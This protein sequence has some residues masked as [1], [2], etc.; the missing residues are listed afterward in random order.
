M[1][2]IIIKDKNSTREA[3][4]Q[5]LYRG[6]QSAN[7]RIREISMRNLDRIKRETSRT[8]SMRQELVKAHRNNDRENIKD[9]HDYIQNKSEYQAHD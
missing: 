7:P 5:E 2:Y 6:T 1:V 8:E 3:D 4:R 9:I